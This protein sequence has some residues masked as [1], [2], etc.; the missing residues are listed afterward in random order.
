ML[1]DTNKLAEAEV[2]FRQAIALQQRLV[3]DFPDVPSYG[4]QLA[5]SYGRLGNTLEK[6]GKLDEAID[7]YRKAVV[8][9]AQN[10]P[11][12]LLAAA[13][14]HAKANRWQDAAASLSEAIELQ[15][16]NAEAW[17]R[18]GEANSR[19]SRY[20]EALK[21]FT[22]NLELSPA[23]GEAHLLLSAFMINHPERLQDPHRAL[24]LAR[25]GFELHGRASWASLVLGQAHYRAGDWKECI[26]VLQASSSSPGS[27]HVAASTWLYLAMAH[28]QLGNQEEARA[29]FE[30]G[31]PV[32]QKLQPRGYGSV[33]R[34][35][36]EATLLLDSKEQPQPNADSK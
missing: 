4:I 3:A 23:S 28:A 13:A 12:Q 15:P 11:A 7:A 9:D 6:Q 27:D 30:K 18:R 1:E 21:D 33:G 19:L 22:R 24:E 5:G 36:T 10:A 25:K 17:K 31:A 14:A 16:T 32:A 35:H 8:A 20:D 29:W 2:E 34:L 26:E